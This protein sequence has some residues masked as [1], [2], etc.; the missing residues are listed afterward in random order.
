MMRRLPQASCLRG[1]YASGALRV[2]V[3]CPCIDRCFSDELREATP[4]R[5]CSVYLLCYSLAQLGRR[6]TDNVCICFN[7]WLLG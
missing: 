3:A 4:S 6:Q 7:T 5:P 1:E 2:C